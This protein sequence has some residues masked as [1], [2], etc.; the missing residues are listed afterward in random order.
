MRIKAW[1]PLIALHCLPSSCKQ[2]IRDFFLTNVRQRRKLLI[3]CTIW[4]VVD[5]PDGYSS[6]TYIPLTSLLN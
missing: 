1:L 3:L 6:F 4:L 2:I 5:Q